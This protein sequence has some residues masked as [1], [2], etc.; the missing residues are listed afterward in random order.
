MGGW[1]CKEN[2]G[3]IFN[4]GINIKLKKI[5]FLKFDIIKGVWWLILEYVDVFVYIFRIFIFL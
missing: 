4:I 5:L 1:S 2:G 3:K